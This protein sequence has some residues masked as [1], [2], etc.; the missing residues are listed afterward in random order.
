MNNHNDTSRTA[1]TA[2]KEINAVTRL[3]RLTTRFAN[4]L[5][6]RH[7]RDFINSTVPELLPLARPAATPSPICVPQSAS[8]GVGP[9]PARRR[10]LFRTV[11]SVTT[12]KSQTKKTASG[13]GTHT[14]F[15]A[16]RKQHLAVFAAASA[17]AVVV[18]TFLPPPASAADFGIESFTSHT[19]GEAA[20]DYTGAGGHPVQNITQFD[21]SGIAS[22]SGPDQ[23]KDAGVDLPLGFFGNP[24]ATPRCSVGLIAF[25]AEF[26]LGSVCPAG[27]AVGFVLPRGD[28]IGGELPLYSVKPDRGY[29]AQFVFRVLNSLISLYVTLRPRTESYGLAVG[30]IDSTG[31]VV[32]FRG[33]TTTFCSHGV[34]GGGSSPLNCK[35]P[36]E[37]V[38]APL[39]TNP[40]DCSDLDPI[41]KLTAD[42]WEDP[43]ARLPN[44][45]P[46]LGDPNWKTATEP[47][48]PVTGCDALTFDPTIAVKPLQESPGPLQAD[49]PS[50]LAVDLDFP[51]VNDPTDPNTTVDNTL[52]QTPEP[53]DITVKLPAGLSISPSS[54]TGLGACSD[55]ASDP[56]GDQVH[57]DSVKPVTCP[58]SSKIGTA[59]ATS[60][61][62]AA[63]HPDTDEVSGPEPI[64]GDVYLLAP[65]PGDLPIGGG[66]QEGK[67]RLLIQLENAQRGVNFK[68]P[69][70]AVAD[71]QTGQITTVF[72]DAPQL[73]S[74]HLTVSL[75]SGARA[76]LMTPVTCGSFQSSANLV[77]W[78]T[79]DVPDAN[80]TASFSVGSGPG[81]SACPVSPAARPFAPALVA[82]GT[83]N[84]AAGSN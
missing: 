60:P 2:S 18:V 81:G 80:K 59:V 57:Y 40:V 72:T 73:P 38:A 12:A 42:S 33:L 7:S 75:K 6:R 46:D 67:F 84:D 65:H 68:L 15:T 74:K 37:S 76:P 45:L 63:R 23:L 22:S 48:L 35:A 55:Q 47:A 17:V 34:A 13:R 66:N 14:A 16:L 19:T 41:W 44:G 1:S 51:Q 30:A 77:P 79:P 83:E 11:S 32:S 52:P 20:A 10:F 50:G 58:D 3:R 71:P 64:P 29:P 54:A 26:P 62:L 78:G 31:R 5:S 8:G 39:L 61:L 24:A 49:Q 25:P 9:P 53:K 36:S 69:G 70:T 27:S 21:F 28:N 43:G 4:A 82:A 56:A